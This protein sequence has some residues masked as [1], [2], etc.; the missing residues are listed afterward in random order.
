M[1]PQRPPVPVHRVVVMGVTGA[2]KSTIGRL[3][4]EAL[5]VP[6]VDADQYH[7]AISIAKMRDG[8]PLTDDDR[9]EWLA[10]LHQVLAAHP[11][12]VVLAASALSRRS[13]DVLGAGLDTIR[14]VLLRGDPDVIAHRLE[15]RVDHFA[16][17]ELLAS[18]LAL[19]DPPPD[20]T[21]LDIDAP[22]ATIVARALDALAELS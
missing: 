16:G 11:D 17:V 14:Y 1:G 3:L 10:R 8:V 18:Q 7:D 2:G 6:F 21:V 20:A 13:R 4:A 12:G 22:P 5:H 15:Q 19:L 9:A